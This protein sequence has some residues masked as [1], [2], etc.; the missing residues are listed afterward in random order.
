MFRRALA[1]LAGA[2]LI[3][4]TIAIDNADAF[5]GGGRGGGGFRGGGV[6]VRGGG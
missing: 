2:V 1:I 6:A 3:S 4:T 5:R